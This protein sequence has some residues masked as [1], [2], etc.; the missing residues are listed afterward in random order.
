[1]VEQPVAVDVVTVA[2]EAGDESHTCM[3]ST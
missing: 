2:K 1:V 3:V